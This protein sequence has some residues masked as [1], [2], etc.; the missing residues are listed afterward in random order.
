[1]SVFFFSF[2]PRD[3]FFYSVRYGLTVNST[4]HHFVVM[5]NTVAALP[6]QE[7]SIETILILPSFLFLL[8]V[9][10]NVLDRLIYCGLIGQVLIG[11]TIGTPGTK[12]LH[13]GTEQSIVQLGYL[14]LIL[15][16]YEGGVSTNFRSLKANAGLSALVAVTGICLPVA[17]AFCLQSI[18]STTPLQAF[19]AGTALCCTSLGTTFTI[20]NTCDL[21]KTR[22]GT[23]LASAA[24]MDDVVGLVM[25]QVIS[26]LGSSPS[27]HLITAAVLR[28]I[29]VSVGLTLFVLLTCRYLVKP[30]SSLIG[31]SASSAVM[32]VL[33]KQEAALVLHTALLFGFVAAASYAGTSNLFAAYLAGA[34][35]GWYDSEVAQP[36][37]IGNSKDI[38][39]TQSMATV[40]V[41]Q[42]AHDE[43]R[44]NKSEKRNSR[45]D[46][47]ENKS[48]EPGGQNGTIARTQSPLSGA[49]IYKKYVEQP[50]ARILKPFFF[51]SANKINS[52]FER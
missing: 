40:L 44:S 41:Q 36:C 47:T 38:E 43:G 46:D 5:N 29:A 16:I 8:N 30:I 45:G 25:V 11:V 32:H 19:A 34:S 28:P 35:I 3:S 13:N 9:I 14:G 15:L 37:D 1:M 22:L 24:M 7:P 50:V 33:S 17:F 48:R 10:N 51:V 20:L 52:E 23:V 26:R 27:S 42:A 12:W 21:T 2:I 31:G 49:S 4:F 6:Y 18:A 39:V